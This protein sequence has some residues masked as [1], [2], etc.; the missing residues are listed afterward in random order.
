MDERRG[1]FGDFDIDSRLKNLYTAVFFIALMLVVMA[2]MFTAGAEPQFFSEESVEKVVKISDALVWSVIILA[3]LGVIV[4]EIHIKINRKKASAFSKSSLKKA[5]FK[6]WAVYKIMQI[7]SV[8]FMLVGTYLCVVFAFADL[9]FW[10]IPVGVYA[11]CS[12]ALYFNTPFTLWE[13]NRQGPLDGIHA[14][15]ELVPT[16]YSLARKAAKKMRIRGG[17][18]IRLNGLDGITIVKL[19]G[20]Y[21][22]TVDVESVPFMTKE[23]IYA[24]FLH[25]FAHYKRE[26]GPRHVFE[27][28][29]TRLALNKNEKSFN[30]L[31][32]PFKL[33]R[34][35]FS[36]NYVAFRMGYSKETELKADKLSAKYSS[37]EDNISGLAKLTMA[38]TVYDFEWFLHDAN[39][40][41]YKSEK[42]RGDYIMRRFKRIL[43]EAKENRERWKEIVNASVSEAFETHPSLKERAEYLNVTDYNIVFLDETGDTA[44]FDEMMSAIRFV[45]REYAKSVEGQYREERTKNYLEP[46]RIIEYNEDKR[47]D[48]ECASKLIDAYVRLNMFEK[49]LELCDELIEMYGD[50]VAFAYW[51]KGVLLLHKYDDEAIEYI[52]HSMSLDSDRIE[53]GK[54]ELRSYFYYTGR[55]E[56]L[57]EYEDT[58]KSFNGI[59]A[60]NMEIGAINES[61][62]LFKATLT[63]EER[64]RIKVF[65][66]S[67]DRNS[68]ERVYIVAKQLTNGDVVNLLIPK[69]KRSALPVAVERTVGS[70]KKYVKSESFGAELSL[71]PCRWEA[72]IESVE[73]CI[74]YFPEN[75]RR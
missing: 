24:S 4:G 58:I 16:L 31:G 67:V 73:D 37:A 57:D 68:L 19:F 6:V 71:V 64:E 28:Y 17:V 44:F 26:C 25:E 54:A 18:K 61:D 22:V 55:T 43:S 70:M 32:A 11:M 62:K 1:I 29:T 36:S 9:S 63:A 15:E 66:G 40:N 72:L 42:N 52:L 74:L 35:L 69:F 50:E 53:R 60:R 13:I 12:G 49:A 34:I 38:R 45:D 8:C 47:F 59:V 56:K 39:D 65:I 5:Y 3:I 30:F 2:F 27:R 75:K 10:Y 33:L 20:R 14:K 23:E 46:M 48:P 41:Y 51:S 7:M 21:Y